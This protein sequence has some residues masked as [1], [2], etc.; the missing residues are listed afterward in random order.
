MLQ[1]TGPEPFALDPIA[2]AMFSHPPSG[3]LIEFREGALVLF[4]G[5]SQ[6]RFKRSE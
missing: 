1:A 6:L 5:P 2:E 4:Q 3:I